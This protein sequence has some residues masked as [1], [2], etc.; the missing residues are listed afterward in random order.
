MLGEVFVSVLRQFRIVALLEGL[1]F[2]LLL[3]VAMPLKYFADMPVAVRIV[4][5]VHGL[6]FVLYV[7]ALFRAASEHAWPARRWIVAFA[8]SFVPF[9][10]FVFDRSLEREIRESS[11]RG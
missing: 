5:A 4:G 8:A 6:L 7:P 11:P 3:F 10:T 2:L 9:G 1:S